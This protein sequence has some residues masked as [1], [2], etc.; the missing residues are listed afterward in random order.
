VRL[1][2]IKTF[3]LV[4]SVLFGL[5]FTNQA[6]LACSCAGPRGVNILS[7]NAAVF[8]GKVTAIVHL[9]SGANV[10]EPPIRVTFDVHEV[11]KGPVRN[12]VILT[13]IYNKFSCEGYFFMEGQHYLV[14]AK[15]LTRDD[16]RSDIAELEGIFL[17]GGTSVLSDANESLKALGNGQRPQ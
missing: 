13:T 7:N 9:E 12:T 6:T 15:T 2:S 1:V 8:A 10:S 11:W 17:C 14:A 3:V 16:G 4:V 5:V